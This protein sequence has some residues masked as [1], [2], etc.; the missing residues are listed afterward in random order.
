MP[1]DIDLEIIS[2]VVFLIRIVQDGIQVIIEIYG[3]DSEIHW[4]VFEYE[5]MKIVNDLVLNDIIFH[6]Y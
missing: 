2:Q 6:L 5:Q 4:Q 1:A 3:D